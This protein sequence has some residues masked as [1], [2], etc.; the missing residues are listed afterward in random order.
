MEK[1][2]NKKN[3]KTHELILLVFVL[4]SMGIILTELIGHIADQLV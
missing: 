4:L 1:N 3:R 2:K